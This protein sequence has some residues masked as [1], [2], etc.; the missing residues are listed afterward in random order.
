MRKILHNLLILLGLLFLAVFSF[1]SCQEDT[2]NTNPDFRLVFSADTLRID[3]I[4]T[5]KGSATY[6]L[7]VY[8]TSAQRHILAKLGLWMRCIF[9]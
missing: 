7:K 2:I 4:F 8:N 1:T 9:T 5:D 6:K 3:T